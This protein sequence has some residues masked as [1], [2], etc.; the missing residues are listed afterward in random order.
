MF[1]KRAQ[2]GSIVNR[3]NHVHG[4]YENIHSSLTSCALIWLEYK[5]EGIRAK[6]EE[7]LERRPRLKEL[8]MP[9]EKT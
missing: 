6:R 3:E 8:C 1:S 7:A 9:H 4:N 5:Q 2:E